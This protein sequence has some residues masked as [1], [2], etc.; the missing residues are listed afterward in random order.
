MLDEY[1]VDECELVETTRDDFG[2]EI[3][4]VTAKLNCRWREI[5]TI[6][7]GSNTD[8]SDADSMVWFNAAAPVKKGAVLLFAGEYYQVERALPAKRLG[9]TI[10]QFIKCTVTRTNLG[11]S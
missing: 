2:Q 9:E 11:I 6:R 10:P 4:G 3:Q 1:L 7:R 8:V 5:N